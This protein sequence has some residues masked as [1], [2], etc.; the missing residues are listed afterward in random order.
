MSLIQL[1]F[2]ILSWSEL[3]CILSFLTYKE[4]YA[5]GSTNKSAFVMFLRQ[6]N[7]LVF[8][9]QSLKNDNLIKSRFLSKYSS[10]DRILLVSYPRS[11]NSFMRRIIEDITGIVTGSDSRPNRTLSASLLRFGYQGEGI[12]DKSVWVVKSHYPERLGYIRFNV[13]K[14]IVLVRNPFDAIES[15]FH[16]GMTNTHDKRLSEKA[17]ATLENVWHDFVKNEALIWQQFHEYWINRSSLIDT[18]FLRY[19]DLLLQ[20]LNTQLQVLNFMK[21]GII[22]CILNRSIPEKIKEMIIQ[23][24]KNQ[25]VNIHENTH[26]PGYKPKQGKIG[27]SLSIMNEK[28]IAVIQQHCHGLMS[29]FGYQLI[30][31]QGNMSNSLEVLNSEIMFENMKQFINSNVEEIHQNKSKKIQSINDA[32]SVRNVNDKFGRKMTDLRRSLT[33][34]DKNPFETA[35]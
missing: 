2:P 22:P 3:S 20:P 26:G 12:T 34:L 14:V 31:N 19:E 15:Y 6:R 24:E 32:Y 13:S 7:L 29:M 16:M 30:S 1:V 10:H 8:V 33:D 9:K 5:L 17:F 25:L 11:G 28:D 18:I 21:D 35:P 23:H 4:L 27:K